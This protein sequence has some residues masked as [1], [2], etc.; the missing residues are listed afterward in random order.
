MG[1]WIEDG[2]EA[3]RVAECVGVMVEVVG[4]LDIV[5]GKTVLYVNHLQRL[6]W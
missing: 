6:N 5:G 1:E 2:V 3:G 4:F